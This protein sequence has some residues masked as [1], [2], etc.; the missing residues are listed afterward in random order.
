[1]RVGADCGNQ[2]ELGH[3]GLGWAGPGQQGATLQATPYG[4]C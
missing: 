4:M 3:A 2:V 1:M